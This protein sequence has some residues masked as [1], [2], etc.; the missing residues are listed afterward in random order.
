M[1]HASHG[2][3]E[4]L[5][6]NNNIKRS[7]S[8]VWVQKPVGPRDIRDKLSESMVRLSL[9][10]LQKRRMKSLGMPEEDYWIDA[11]SR[12]EALGGKFSSAGKKAKNGDILLTERFLQTLFHEFFVYVDEMVNYADLHYKTMSRLPYDLFVAGE[13]T[14]LERTRRKHRIPVWDSVSPRQYY[15]SV[16]QP[17]SQSSTK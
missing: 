7:A 6:K 9:A 14:R 1:K 15:K 12:L 11:G 16:V 5:H 3:N 10:I 2:Q 8:A 17:E 4:L 13:H